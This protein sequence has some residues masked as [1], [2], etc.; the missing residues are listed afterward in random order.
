MQH[1]LNMLEVGQVFDSTDHTAQLLTL[2][3][4]AMMYSPGL[5]LL[6]P[7]CCFA[8]T[9]YFRVDKYLLCRYY[10]KPPHI[11]DEAMRLVVSYLPYAAVIRLGFACWMYGN[12]E[13]LVTSSSASTLAYET[14]LA[15]LR[16]SGTGVS[17][18]K[19]KI[20]RTNVFPLFVLLLA[21]A[22]GIFVNQ[23]WKQL[24]IFWTYK[25][26]M[27]IFSFVYSKKDIFAKQTDQG[28]ITAW[29][30]IRLKD[31]NRHQ[32]CPFT[33]EY[34]RFI[35]HK[36]EIPDTCIQMFEYAYLTQLSEVEIEEGW[37]TEDRRDFVVQIKVWMDD[38]MRRYDGSRT[39]RGDRK[40][41]FEVIADHRCSSYDVERVPAYHL[42]IKGLR[43]GTSSVL[44]D[45][46]NSN[47]MFE[48]KDMH[49][50]VV[51]S[52]EK[53]G[54]GMRKSFFNTHNS[55]KSKKEGEDDIELGGPTDLQV[56]MKPS[57][58]A[59]SEVK[60]LKIA[61]DNLNSPQ[62]SYEHTQ[63]TAT[64]T[65]S[66]PSYSTSN[67]SKPA[68]RNFTID[69]F[70]SGNAAMHDPTPEEGNPH[71]RKKKNNKH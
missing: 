5:P 24:P 20:F 22:A 8:F 69:D 25:L 39:K 13:I 28:F 44:L 23:F 53:H 63:N 27:S 15:N 58:V 31:P 21:V 26:I 70:L 9:L 14:F 71:H 36:D 34:F 17:F 54:K 52:Y 10:Q 59:S 64:R 46:E 18:A 50:S 62:N 37:K 2:L 51:E 29:D 55:Q 56:K 32:S 68:G 19:N 42:A 40:S 3:F 45:G 66:K 7:L 30:L 33:G 4:F 48:G 1:D 60:P 6:M 57:G 11:G 65:G 67:D 49:L 43:E 12:T 38:N 35:K 61:V 47:K 41:T 16:E